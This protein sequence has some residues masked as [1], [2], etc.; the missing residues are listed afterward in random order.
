MMKNPE[1]RWLMMIIDRSEGMR[2]M[3]HAN[4]TTTDHYNL[5]KCLGQEEPSLK[6]IP[7]RRVQSAVTSMKR[8]LCLIIYHPV[9]RSACPLVSADYPC[10][11]PRLLLLIHRILSRDGFAPR[12]SFLLLT[13]SFCASSATK[14]HSTKLQFELFSWSWSWFW[15][16]G[17]LWCQSWGWSW[18]QSWG[19]S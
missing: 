12:L 10:R 16:G 15:S 8:A 3:N 13:S 1:L 5:W 14:S 2:C 19:R 6:A 4:F 7:G 11:V 17:L 18:G 9:Q